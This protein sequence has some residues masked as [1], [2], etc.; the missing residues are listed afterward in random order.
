MRSKEETMEIQYYIVLYHIVLLLAGFDRT[1]KR[2]SNSDVF[3][4]FLK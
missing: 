4:I 2:M 1:P 3:R